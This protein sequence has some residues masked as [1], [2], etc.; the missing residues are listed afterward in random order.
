MPLIP[1][2]E[3]SLREPEDVALGD[4]RQA[5]VEASARFQRIHRLNR[6]QRPVGLGLLPVRGQGS[7]LILAWSRKEIP[8]GLCQCTHLALR[9]V[10]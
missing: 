5:H 7:P 8:N 2:D 4:L 6:S 1:T 3:P 10:S 9:G